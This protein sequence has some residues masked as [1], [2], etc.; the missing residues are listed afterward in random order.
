MDVYEVKPLSIDFERGGTWNVEC[1]VPGSKSI[2]NRAFLLAALAEGGSRLDGVAMHKDGEVFLQCLEA[3]GYE[4]HWESAESITIYGKGGDVPRKAGEVY[5]GSAGTAAR[6]ITA[7]LACS[8]GQYL[9]R[10][11]EQMAARPMEELLV[12]LE[13]LGAR[14]AYGGSPRHLPYQVTG[15]N[16]GADG[17]DVGDGNAGDEATDSKSADNK[18]DSESIKLRL[19]IDRSSQ[20]LSAL[21]MAAPLCGKP[22]E[23]ALVGERTA[24]AY[25][26]ITTKMMED[27]GCPASCHIDEGGV[28]YKVPYGDGYRAR[29]YRVEP[30]A[31]SACYFYAMAACTG[32]TALVNG[33]RM[34]SIQGDVKFLTVLERMG[35][36]LREEREGVRL[37][38][39]K[40]GRLRGLDVDL[41][42]CSDQ[43]M[44]LAA[45]APFADSPV[46]IRGVGHI[47]VQESN[48][49]QAVC[50]ELEGMGVRTEQGGTWLRI[51]PGRPRATTVATYDDHRMAMAFAITGLRT[52]GMRIA[53]PNCC[54]KTFPQYFAV[55]ESLL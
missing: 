53:N 36:L 41:S 40:G 23:V 35:C 7:M 26:T 8:D 33:V 14:F 17:E 13:G 11:S 20:F 9:V 10:S 39:P 47:R 45:I 42:D 3:L 52:P 38:G 22:L 37:T 43:T 24:R 28:T 48:R 21:L 54:A 34:D 2:T 16:H 5:V 27:F 30:D 51:H 18:A 6:F 25:V 15:R 55:L 31:S 4:Y 1:S 29:K 46:T 19:N 49:I 32:G 44:T 12:A 50:N